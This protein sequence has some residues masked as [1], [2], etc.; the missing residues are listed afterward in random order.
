MGQIF[1]RLPGRVS[2]LWALL[3]GLLRRDEQESSS[4]GR[5]RRLCGLRC[6]T[7][8]LF[9]LAIHFFHL[10]C[11]L[12]AYPSLRLLLPQDNEWPPVLIEYHRHGACRVCAPHRT[13]T[14]QKTSFVWAA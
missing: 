13:R 2:E 4:G 5:S 1:S 11:F 12:P 6:L 9:S 8:N 10:L 14:R 3:R 7:A